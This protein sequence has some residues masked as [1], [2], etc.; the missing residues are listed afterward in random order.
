[1]RI[2]IAVILV[3]ACGG[4]AHVPTEHR[5]GVADHRIA[6]AAHEARAATHEAEAQEHLASPGGYVCGDA[7]LADQL[8]SGGERIAFA[9]PCWNT[10]LDAGREHQRAA[11]RERA[12][13]ARHR[14]VASHL[15]SVERRSCTGMLRA[16]ERRHPVPVS[17]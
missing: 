4:A 3:A 12:E 16:P 7:V 11:H 2:A 1:M 13:A 9:I 8:T 6:A 10:D 17:A 5:L 15:A 14:I